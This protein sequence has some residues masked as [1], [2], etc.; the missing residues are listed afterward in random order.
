[1]YSKSHKGRH[2]WKIIRSQSIP[3]EKCTNLFPMFP[4]SW[5]RF[6][7]RIVS[8]GWKP[9]SCGLEPL[10][11]CNLQSLEVEPWSEK[12]QMDGFFQLYMWV[13]YINCPTAGAKVSSRNRNIN[14]DVFLIYITELF[15]KLFRTAV[16]VIC[17]QWVCYPITHMNKFGGKVLEWHNICNHTGLGGG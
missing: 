11:H 8:Q 16:K 9:A 1:M 15:H 2:L 12:T 6:W 7:I 13:N 14:V 10:L 17:I 3:F 5:M 4:M